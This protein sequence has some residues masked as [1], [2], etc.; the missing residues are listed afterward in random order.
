MATSNPCK[1]SRLDATQQNRK[2]EIP[3]EK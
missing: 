2:D 3:I 1:L